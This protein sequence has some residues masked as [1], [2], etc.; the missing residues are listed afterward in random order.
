V[1]LMV[2]PNFKLYF[3]ESGTFYIY[4]ARFPSFQLDLPVQHP[5]CST[6]AV[7]VCDLL[8]EMIIC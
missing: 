5:F 4:L 8:H 2:V 1:R 7:K 3:G 6:H